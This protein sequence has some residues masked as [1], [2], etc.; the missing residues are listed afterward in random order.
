MLKNKMDKYIREKVEQ[1]DKIPLKA[2][3]I[4]KNFEEMIYMKDDEK[5]VIRIGLKTFMAV[6][7]SFVIITFLGVNI[8]ANKMGKPNVI[9]AVKA[10]FKE[11]IKD[12][13]NEKIEQLLRKAFFD[14]RYLYHADLADEYG[15]DDS[16]EMKQIGEKTYYKTMSKY[17]S[18]EEKYSEMLTDEALK[19][20]LALRFLNVNGDLYV[21]D[22]ETEEIEVSITDIQKVNEEYGIYT[23]EIKSVEIVYGDEME[24][25]TWYK[26]KKVGDSYKICAVSFLQEESQNVAQQEKNLMMVYVADKSDFYK[27]G[28]ENAEVTVYASMGDEP[29]QVETVYTDKD[30]W[31]A[32][33]LNKLINDSKNTPCTIF[34]NHGDK[35]AKIALHISYSDYK[36]EKVSKQQTTE[37][38]GI[39]YIGVEEDNILELQWYF[40]DEIVN[41]DNQ[42][43]DNNNSTVS[44]TI[45]GDANCDGEVN[46]KDSVYIR[47]YVA[48]WEGYALTEQGKINADVNGDGKVEE[49]DAK[50]I[51]EYLAGNYKQLP[52][53]LTSTTWIEKSVPG[54]SLKYPSD[55]T[56]TEVN[57]SAWNFQQGELAC[58]FEGETYGYNF[59]VSVY[60]PYYDSNSPDYESLM[61]IIAQK[62][63]ETYHEA[64]GTTGYNI[65][66]TD[67][68]YLEWRHITGNSNDLNTKTD[69][70]YHVFLGGWVYKIVVEYTVIDE[71]ATIVTGGA[72]RIID[73]MIGSI[74]LRSY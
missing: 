23:Y 3:K 4:V 30:G 73:E 20:L 17:S 35:S 38:G 53:K 47:R 8:Y 63:G 6:A 49:F 46:L 28:L 27:K 13:E 25:T 22:L 32:I 19:N 14:I 12:D 11:D 62:R 60:E 57:R 31:A 10:L 48:G 52:V 58:I 66:S 34:I 74:E 37:N 43:T 42:T 72:Y 68:D 40:E 45:Y 51:S 44:K 26:V 61:R 33:G 16:A 70:Y 50:V 56:V 2:E 65:G 54:M 71:N 9:S 1:D 69:E 7:A 41:E 36:F 59:K 55:W 64:Y 24:A 18:V 21:C 15:K 39:K 5:K 29:Q 67:E